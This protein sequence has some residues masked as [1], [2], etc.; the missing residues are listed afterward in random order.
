MTNLVNLLDDLSLKRYISGLSFFRQKRNVTRNEF[1]WKKFGEKIF[2]FR[3]RNNY[4]FREKT[5]GVIRRFADSF[6]GSRMVGS[7]KRRQVAI[8]SAVTEGF[9]PRAAHANYPVD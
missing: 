1:R 4:R 5:D 8:N 3:K 6:R 7:A 2:N 9:F